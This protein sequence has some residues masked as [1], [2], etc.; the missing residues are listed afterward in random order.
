MR[1]VRGTGFAAHVGALE[2]AVGAACGAARA[3]YDAVQKRVHHKGVALV[4]CTDGFVA[5]LRIVDAHEHLAVDVR[6]FV[7]EVG[8]DAIAAVGKHRE[9]G[10]HFPGRG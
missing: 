10:S 4:D 7:D 8:L 9:G 5:R 2:L 1:V 3:A 6:D